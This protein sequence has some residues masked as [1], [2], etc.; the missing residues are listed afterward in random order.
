MRVSPPVAVTLTP[1]QETH[2]RQIWLWRN[3]EDTRR[4][5]FEPAPIPFE[6]HER[7][8]RDSLRNESRKLYIVVAGDRPSGVVRFDITERQATVSIHLAPKSR[9]RGIGPAALREASE[10]AFRELGLDCLLAVVKPDNHPSQSAFR[11]A[12]FT[13]SP[14]G[15]VVVLARLRDASV[16]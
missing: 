15:P 4:A 3:D 10:L 12:G 11:R 2:C 14:T 6:T 8:F 13:A 7:W 16:S 5:S 1:A 9:G